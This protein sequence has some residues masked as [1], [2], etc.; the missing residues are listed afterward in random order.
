MSGSPSPALR[1]LK[2]AL[3]T[4]ATNNPSSYQT[5]I[6]Q[7]W[8]N[9]SSPIALSRPHSVALRNAIIVALDVECCNDFLGC[10]YS[11]DERFN[12]KLRTPRSQRTFG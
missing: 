1:E 2:T 7:H 10:S 9:S 8:L 3:D 5:S 12:N 6:F 4:L 11:N